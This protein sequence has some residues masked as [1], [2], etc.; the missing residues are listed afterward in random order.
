MKSDVL[1]KLENMVY[2]SDAIA[3]LYAIQDLSSYKTLSPYSQQCL[4]F[5]HAWLREQASFEILTSGSTGTPKHIRITRTQMQASAQATAQALGLKAGDKALV[6]LNTAYIAGKMMLVRG[7]ER[8]MPLIVIPP[9]STPLQEVNE[10]IEF[11]ALVPLQLKTMLEAPDQK[12]MDQLNAMKAILVGGAAV[13]HTLEKHI[14]DKISAPVF[15]TYGM[16]E[17]VSHI[18]LRRINGPE[19]TDTYQILPGVEVKKDWRD[20]LSIRGAVSNYQWLQTNDIVEFSDERHFRWLG[21]A[22]NV[23]NS[24]GIKIYTEALESKLQEAMHTIGIARHFF[25]AG[26]PDERL[27]EKLCLT[28]EGKRMNNE[29]EKQLNTWMKAH[30][31]PYEVPKNIFYLSEFIYTPSGKIQRRQSLEMIQ[32][33]D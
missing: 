30:L 21:R 32:K 2:S 27:G 16:T 22:D 20:C 26:L 31:H 11:T 5:C 29:Q 13:D 9:T 7:L 15:G 19:A 18:A 17:T 28:I 4:S 25:L 12:Y 33:K 23:I 14:R 6:C 1:I 24:G 8:G 3:Q 10:S